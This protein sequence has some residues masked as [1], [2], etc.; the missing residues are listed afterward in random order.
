MVDVPVPPAPVIMATPGNLVGGVVM[1]VRDVLER[2]F[3]AVGIQVV[4]MSQDRG[5]GGDQFK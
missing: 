5:F 3:R 2:W 1:I 4:T